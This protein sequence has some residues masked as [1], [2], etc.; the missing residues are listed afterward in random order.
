MSI[1]TF[2][3]TVLWSLLLSL[4]PGARAAQV[5]TVAVV[6]Q[7]RPE[8]ISRDWTLVLTEVSRLTG[9]HL[10]LQFY[11]SIAEFE[12]DFLNNWQ[13]LWRETAETIKVSARFTQNWCCNV[14]TI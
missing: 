5:F 10:K 12:I 13:M 11:A 6:P 8:Q 1:R 14:K 7:F 3:P 2:L 4:N 9:L